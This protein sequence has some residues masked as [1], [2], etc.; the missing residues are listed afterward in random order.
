V[1]DDPARM[2]ALLQTALDKMFAG[3]P[4]GSAPAK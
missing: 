2:T 1:Q 3:F 4:P